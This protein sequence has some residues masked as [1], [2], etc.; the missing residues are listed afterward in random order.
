MK[1]VLFCGGLGLR[2]RDYSEHIPKPMVTIGYRPILWHIMKYYAHFGHRDFILCLGY[3]GDV[4]KQYFLTYSECISNDFVVSSGGKRLQLF[5]TDIDDWTITCADTGTHANIGQR[6]KA[7]AKYLDDDEV[8]L[9]NYGDGL[10]DV[11]LDRQ[12]EHFYRSEKVASFLCVKPNLS[13]H[14]ISLGKDDRVEAIKD[15]GRSDDIRINGGF[16][17][18]RRDVFDYMRDGEDLLGPPFHRLLQAGQLA[19]YKYDGFWACM[20]TFK[21]R[22]VLEEMY[23]RGGSPWEVWKTGVARGRNGEA[24]RG[25]EPSVPPAVRRVGQT[26]A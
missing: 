9:A 6:L 13:S 12:I 26:A 14:F 22:Q 23:A 18:L 25:F 19:A 11:P 10:S 1:V 17:V 7:V 24:E 3:G 16:F 8:F 15:G 2:L 5:N 20:D 4:I 21:D